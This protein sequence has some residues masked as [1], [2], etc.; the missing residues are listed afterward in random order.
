MAT[1]YRFLPWTRRGLAAALPDGGPPGG[2]LPQRPEIAVKVV[3]ARA[4]EASTTAL[5]HGPGDVI[6]LDPAQVVRTYPRAY[7]T[8]AEPNYL[9]A[10]DLDAPEL[11]WLFTP[12]G[13]PA[14]GHLPPWLVLIVV[15]QRAGVAVTVPAGAPLP[16]LR[17]DS[18]AER[19][20]PDLAES[21][22]WAHVQ[23]VEPAGG[24]TSA[25]AV[26]TTLEAEPDRNVARLV[27]PRRLAPNRRWIAALVPAFDVG[28]TRGLGGAPAADAPVR[29][30]WTTGQSS[31]T[32]PTYFHWEFQT[33]P[34]GDF[35]SLAQRLKPHKAD[36]RVGLVGMHVGE[37][38]PPIRVPADQTRI[39]DMDGA[40]RAPAQSDGRLD[41]VPAALRT[42]LKEVTRTLADAAD[43]VLDGQVL[44]DASRQPVGPPVYASAQVRRWR[45][46]DQE[47]PQDATWFRE[48]N[49]D[50]RAR[51]AAG[52]GA[53]CVRVNQ[54]DIA[55]AAWQQVG[56]V[57]AAQAALQRA[58]LSELVS[59]SFYRRTIVALP[60][61]RLLTMV[62]PMATRVPVAG[63]SL[64]ASVARTSLPDAVLD[65]GLRRALAPAGRA[66]ARAA[67]RVGIAVG[68]VR[69]G[70]VAGL[71]R[72]RDDLDAT[73]FARPVLTGVAPDALRGKDL[74]G[75]GL[76]VEVGR[77]VVKALASTAGAWAAVG[78]DTSPRLSLRADVRTS[79]LLG[80]AHIEAARTL[81]AAA[82]E[83]VGAAVAGGGAAVDVA[84]SV[85]V[86]TG[87]LLDGFSAASAAAIA[88]DPAGGPGLG[89]LVEGPAFAAGTAR[90]DATHA[91][92]TVGVL[93]VDAGNTLVVRSGPGR[94]NTAIAVV[95]GTLAG[96]L[97]GADLAAILSRLPSGA[98]HIADPAVATARDHLPLVRAA[99]PST[100]SGGAAAVLRGD[101]RAATTG[102]V[103]PV[104]RGGASATASRAA[105]VVRGRGTRA[106]GSVAS[107]RGPAGPILASGPVAGPHVVDTP[108]IV[109]PAGV[110]VA[111][112]G[113]DRA[114]VVVPP[115]IREPAVIT[116][117]ETAVAM[118]RDTTV[119]ATA[120][121]VATLVPYALAS[122]SA[123][124]RAHVDPA[125][126]QPLRRDA[127][128]EFAGR[129]VGTLTGSGEPVTVDGW[130]ASRRLDRIMA[131]PRFTVAASDYLSAYDRT[132]FCP[133][134]DSI[135]TDSVTLLET[136]P[137]FIAAFMAGLNYETNRELLWRGFPTDSRGTPFRRFWRRLDGKDDIPPIH[138]WRTGNLAQQTTDPKGNLVLLIR[139][140]LLRRY[141]NTIALAMPALGERQ[142]DHDRAIP[143][144]FSGQFDPDV[145]FFGFPLVDTQLEEGNG[146]FFALMEPVTEPRFGLDETVGGPAG[147]DAAN[148]ADALAWPDTGVA[149]GAYLTTAQFGTL[150]LS[151]VAAGSDD[152]AGT[153]FQRP[154][155]LYV[156][157]KHL[158][159][160]LPEQR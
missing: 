110:G 152:V 38:G 125:V 66:V 41:G 23:L 138:G 81:A 76:P 32:L 93:D 15:E 49:L 72:G 104:A 33:G 48:L 71:A 105:A 134:V 131:Y 20:L 43:G 37:G 118:Q 4:G 52:L 124:V 40:L 108:V 84:T 55:N 117:F 64:T 129:K 59:T 18:G 143:P 11:P 156:H 92:V 159:S 89:F 39:M 141:P 79:G 61:D 56:D 100:T 145:S 3:V 127:L 132:R 83:S 86:S 107:G 98:L 111:A 99:A 60:D 151:P 62:A 142:P 57:L 45:V 137:R 157:A 51:V 115:L 103:A 68:A 58:A 136:N 31:I 154:F 147:G 116:R 91:A 135:P 7:T 74:A 8:D 87:A 25:A 5:L 140:D 155:A 14:G 10:V 128:L 122:V 146:W 102:P 121:P 67:S 27:C 119:L 109:G 150:G 75:I 46:L 26:G 19:E 144:I 47:S 70:L 97:A 82:Q 73:R 28:R 133:G 2:D 126:A 17:I 24:A 130:W 36:T 44:V 34:E 35:E 112:A 96:T 120:T 139:G 160:P 85:A 22:A 9:A 53:E 1:T 29:P 101:A 106:V 30:A 153:L 42:G 54:E 69:P 123:S 13:V 95:D 80:Q 113:R 88:A 16:Q 12:R 63:L 158:V 77:E 65:A 94:A 6:G 148:A 114:S 78:A 149:P 21:W 50:P 90:L